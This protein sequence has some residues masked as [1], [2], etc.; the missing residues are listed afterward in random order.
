[1]DESELQINVDDPF[2][3]GLDILLPESDSDSLEKDEREV[4]IIYID[5]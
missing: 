1:M 2:N 4:H 3:L 5:D